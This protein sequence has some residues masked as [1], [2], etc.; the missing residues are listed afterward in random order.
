MVMNGFAY[1]L[2]AI[3]CVFGLVASVH[4]METEKSEGNYFGYSIALFLAIANAVCIGLNVGRAL[5]CLF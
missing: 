4:N 5:M 2:L 1:I 3:L